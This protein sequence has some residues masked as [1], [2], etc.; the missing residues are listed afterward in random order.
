MNPAHVLKLVLLICGLAGSG[1]DLLDYASSEGYWRREQVPMTAEAMLGELQG[2]APVDVSQL[3][4]DLGSTDPDVRRAAEARAPYLG[5]A[6]L[7][8][9]RKGAA[10]VNPLIAEQAATWLR[11]IELAPSAGAVRRLMAIRTAGELRSPAVLPIL[12]EWAGS[13]EPFVAEYAAAAA[14]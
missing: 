13:A 14:E 6:A 9:L 7:P 11:R 2:A 4:P 10:S 1:N 5:P 8:G 3:L 12:R